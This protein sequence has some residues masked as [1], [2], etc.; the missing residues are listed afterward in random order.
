MTPRSLFP[1]LPLL[2]A[3][4]L[5][6]TIDAQ[7][8]ETRAPKTSIV[9]PVKTLPAAKSPAGPTNA[10]LV[11]AQATPQVQPVPAPGA[12]LPEA[13]IFSPEPEFDFGEILQ[14]EK[15]SHTF[16][17]GNRGA[18]NISIRAVNPTCGCTIAEVTAPDGSLIDPKKHTPN[19]DMLTLEPGDNCTVSVEFNSRGQPLHALQ[20]HIMVISSDDRMPALRLTM[21]MKVTSGIE[22]EPNPL[23]FGEV[24]RGQDVTKRA[25]AKLKTV[26]DIEVTAVGEKPEYVEVK[27]ENAKAPDGTDAI[28]ID[29]TLKGTAPIGY[30]APAL[31]L[32]TN[33][34]KLNQIQVQ[35]YAHV[36]SEVVFDTGNKINKERI[37]FEVIPFGEERARTVEIRNG[38]PSVPYPVTGVELDSMHKDKINVELET[39]EDGVHYKIHLKTAA[40]LDARFFRGKVLV[41]SGSSEMPVKE[42]FFH[43]WVKK[44]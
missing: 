29:V 19:T 24:T 11:P 5:A 37:D 33:H 7:T 9:A 34:A 32:K 42:I 26:K 4:L 23:Q 18:K 10:K 1:A 22:L 40:D 27:W 35:L 41:K 25:W 38:N 36:K 16:M 17:V 15:R 8:S 28:A 14:G 3:V 2:T 44:G 39:V 20:K 6:S 30:V 12:R 31:V 13:S 43:G 21:K